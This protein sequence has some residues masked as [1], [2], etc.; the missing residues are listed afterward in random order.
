MSCA[1]DPSVLAHTA[2]APPCASASDDIANQR[3]IHKQVGVDASQFTA[4]LGAVT[5]RGRTGTYWHQ[6]SDRPSAK[7]GGVDV[8]HNSYVRY[9]SKRTAQL[10]KTQASQAAAPGKGGKRRR[11]GMAS[12]GGPDGMCT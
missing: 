7:K 6:A 10:Y 4:L 12:L 5:A 2:S 9:L 3:R 1:C 11:V 8:K